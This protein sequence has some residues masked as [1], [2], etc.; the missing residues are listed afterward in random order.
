MVNIPDKLNVCLQTSQCL[1]LHAY[2]NSHRPKD[3][4]MQWS[5]ICKTSRAWRSF[6]KSCCCKPAASSGA[7]LGSAYIPQLRES[8]KC[9]S[10]LVKAR[11]APCL[12]S[13]NCQQD[14]SAAQPFCVPVLQLQCKSAVES[15]VHPP[16]WVPLSVWQPRASCC[17]RSTA[18]VSFLPRNGLVC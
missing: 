18:H 2:I 8:L 1:P 15:W 7:A 6:T 10:E 5:S 14:G 9:T 13:Q 16:L 12:W 11:L 3:W 4:G 17:M